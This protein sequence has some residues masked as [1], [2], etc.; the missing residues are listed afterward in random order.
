MVLLGLLSSVNAMDIQKSPEP[1]K[2]KAKT[3]LGLYTTAT[4]AAKYL[5]K[6]KNAIFIDVRSPAEVKFIG[7]A[8][9]MDFHVPYMIL[10]NNK[11]VAKKGSYGMKKNKYAVAEIIY[12]L[13]KRSVKKNS[14]IFVTCRSGSSRAAPV[15]NQLADKGYTNVWTLIDG[16]E[17]GKAKTGKYKG[18]RVKDGWLHS[19]LEWSWKLPKEKL[20]FECKYK[21]LFNKQDVKQCK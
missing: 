14:P 5:K 17:G 6:D 8:K 7:V 18:E 21:H 3:K 11:Y 9:R 15:V 19:G 13:D 1:K 20:W 10:D 12:E 4:E 2:A 16:F